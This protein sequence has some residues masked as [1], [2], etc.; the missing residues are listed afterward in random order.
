[1]GE[2]FPLL[3]KYSLFIKSQATLL[4]FFTVH[5]GKLKFCMQPLIM[6]KNFGRYLKFWKAS[7]G[8][9]QSDQL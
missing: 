8:R 4:I 6:I 9:P 5:P 3:K 1:M 2:K 7:Q